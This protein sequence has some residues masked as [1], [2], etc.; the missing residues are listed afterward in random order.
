MSSMI[1]RMATAGHDSFLAPGF[2]GLWWDPFDKRNLAIYLGIGP[3]QLFIQIQ[4]DIFDFAAF[5]LDIHF[6]GH[7]FQFLDVFD[8]I[9][10]DFTFQNLS[11]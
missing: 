1:S 5:G 8:L 11:E 3:L 4:G 9:V 10:R 6:L 2:Q 7:V